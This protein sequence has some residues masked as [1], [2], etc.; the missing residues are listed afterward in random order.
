MKKERIEGYINWLN[1]RHQARNR[2]MALFLAVSIVLSGNV[3]W[4]LRN[5]GVA[6]AD[7]YTCGLSEHTH[8]DECYEEQL[9]CGETDPEHIHD[10]NCYNRVLTCGHDEHTHTDACRPEDAASRELQSEWESKLPQPVDKKAQSLVNTAASQLDYKEDPDGYTRYGAWYGNPTGDW[11]VMFV[12]FCLHYSGISEN[13]IP[14]GSG[15]WAWQVKL[16]KCGLLNRDFTVLPQM[17]DLLL[18]DNDGDGKCDLTGI[19]VDI[20]DKEISVMEGDIDGAVAVKPYNIPDPALY[21]YVSVNKLDQVENGSEAEQAEMSDPS[22]TTT[23]PETTGSEDPAKRT[24]NTND[25]SDGSEDPDSTTVD[26]EAVTGSGITVKATAPEGA[27]PDGT[28]MA[29]V[30]I[31]DEDIIL[32]ASEAVDKDK[33]VKAAVAVDIIFSDSDGNEIEPSEGTDVSVSI[34]IPEDKRCDSKEANLFHI[35][36]EGVEKVEDARIT[37]S[38]AQFTS[39]GF[40]IYVVTYLGERDKDKVHETLDPVDFPWLPQDNGYIANQA[41]YPYII[42]VGETVKIVGEYTASGLSVGVDNG[43]NNPGCIS[44]ASGTV[45]NM[46]N[47]KYRVEAEITGLQ[48][49]DARVVLNNNGWGINGSDLYIRVVDDRSD[50]RQL[51]FASDGSLAAY[52]EYNHPMQVNIGD[53]FDLTGWAPNGEHFVFIDR[54]GNE[55]SQD[56]V[57]RYIVKTGESYDPTNQQITERIRFCGENMTDDS[58]DPL[59]VIGVKIQGDRIVYFKINTRSILDH[60]DIEIADEGIYTDSRLYGENGVLKKRITEYQ[61][62]VSGVNKCDL[63]KDADDTPTPF[64]YGHY[65]DFGDG[66]EGM[67]PEAITGYVETDYWQNDVPP[68]STQY[69]L[70]SKYERD[71]NDRSRYINIS[72]KQYFYKDVDHV[73]F[74][75]KLEL[76]P[77]HEYTMTLVNGEWVVDSG[78]EIT[79]QYAYDSNNVVTNCIKT[80]SS[81]S[82]AVQYEDIVS[83]ID[84]AEFRLGHHAVIDAYNKCPLNNG[85]DFTIQ[86]NS[87]LVEF[88]AYKELLGR[89]LN[90]GEFRFGLY[91]NEACTGEPV[92]EAVNDTEGQVRFSTRHFERDDEYTFYIKEI[93]GDDENIRYDPTRYK[94]VIKVKNHIADIISFERT[95]DEGQWKNANEFEFSNSVRYTLPNTGGPGITPVVAAGIVMIGGA[96]MLLIIRRRKEVDL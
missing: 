41:G 73:V 43:Y 13:D 33:V 14:Y 19:I 29:A 17:G 50:N 5:T 76:R 52:R 84:H 57:S 8:S 62:Y 23:A 36:E 80:T 85:L 66:C 27:F 61:S 75:V 51:N 78:S 59:C 93:S 90:N 88:V 20:N 35:N 15:G 45:Q 58:A 77:M 89:S 34:F 46:G 39:N 3:F 54:Y 53:E 24:D 95:D 18:I 67:Y 21:A 4:T 69:E 1:R 26:F 6:L 94:V 40:S 16:D 60:A 83:H 63:Y 22:E 79:Y 31:F 7:E 11:N 9:I 28:T 10:E 71:P 72:R 44:V 49:G 48:S 96:L 42:R 86:A 56:V 30:D 70:T 81:G 12:S 74:D 25:G 32:Q 68:G 55:L 65:E 37:D 91:D 2:S 47:G 82:E 38:E 64:Y 92:D 87:A